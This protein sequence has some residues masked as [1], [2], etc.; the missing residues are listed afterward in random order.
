MNWMRIAAVV[1][2][3][4]V[5]LG[6][7]GAHGLESVLS[8]GERSEW[9]GTAV[10]YHMWH[11]LALLGV[12]WMVERTGR[13][14]AAGWCFLLGVTVFSGTLYG[15]GLGGPRWLGAITPLGGVL[16]LAGWASLGIATRGAGKYAEA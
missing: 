12:G 9:W 16:L 15:L 6:A 8:V 14:A 3:T 7:F 5:T 4:G 10:D 2:F 11:A 1:G 13:G